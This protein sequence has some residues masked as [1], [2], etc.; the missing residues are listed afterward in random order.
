MTLGPRPEVPTVLKRHAD[1]D[2]TAPDLVASRGRIVDAH[3]AV[4]T[5]ALARKQI[6]LPAGAAMVA[7]ANQLPRGV[8]AL[9]R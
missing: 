8:L 6:L 7:Q 2:R 1:K 5:A 4:E 3:F 9:L